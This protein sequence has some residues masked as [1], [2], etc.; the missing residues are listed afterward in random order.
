MCLRQGPG[1]DWA[2][3]SA[4]RRETAGCVVCFPEMSE[5]FST[6]PPLPC[7]VPVV[8]DASQRTYDTVDKR[9][10]MRFSQI[11]KG[12]LWVISEAFVRALSLAT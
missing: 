8:G 2:A 3:A 11:K 12:S 9:D 1:S 6:N 7:W 10:S 5:E 4:S